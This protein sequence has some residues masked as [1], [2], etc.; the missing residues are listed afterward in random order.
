MT[1]SAHL[2][3]KP[4]TPPPAYSEQPEG[5]QQHSTPDQSASTSPYTP[6]GAPLPF[7]AHAGYGPTPIPQQTQLLPYYDP[8]S[9]YAL[10]AARSRARWRFIEAVLWAVVILG[11]VSFLTGWE[12]Q[13]MMAKGAKVEPGYYSSSSGSSR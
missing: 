10:A 5:H 2:S 6:I 3:G 4:P 8:R 1:E 7:P 12:I 9:P 13:V 11:F